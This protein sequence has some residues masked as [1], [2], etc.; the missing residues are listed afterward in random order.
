M[1]W[2]VGLSAVSLGTLLGRIVLLRGM[3]GFGGAR[4]FNESHAVASSEGAP[5][6]C[7]FCNFSA[8]KLAVAYSMSSPQSA[9]RELRVGD[10]LDPAHWPIPSLQVPSV[11]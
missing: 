1:L 8:H 4:V 10:P 6:S 5:V 2:I 9:R 7:E 11:P 3:E